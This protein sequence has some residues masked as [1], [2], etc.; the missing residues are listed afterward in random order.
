MV[1]VA[2]EVLYTELQQQLTLTDE[3]RE[4]L[5]VKRGFTDATID[6]LG[7]KSAIAS[8]GDIINSMTDKHGIKPMFECGLIEKNKA[9][10]WQFTQ[11][12]LI[13]IPYLYSDD[14]VYFY[15]SHK[16]AGLKDSG[17]MPYCNKITGSVDDDTIVL[18]ESEFKAAAM[19]QM[20][21]KAL[22]LGGV[23]SFSG[24]HLDSLAAVLRG[25]RRIVI[26]FDTEVQDDPSFS[27]FKDSYKKRY[28]QY[29]WSYI[30][31]K[32]LHNY[33]NDENYKC[34]VEIASLPEEWMIDGKADIDSCVAEGKGREDFELIV[35]DALSPEAYR[36]WIKVDHQHLPWV[37][38]RMQAAFKN[39]KVFEEGG[40][41][42]TYV[43]KG[44]NTYT[45]Q[46][47]N[48]R[49]GLI[50][51]TKYKGKI[52]RDVQLINE[53]GDRSKSFHLESG[54]F[55]SISTFKES[56]L[57]TGDFLWR[58]NE[59]D[60]NNV[61]QAMFLETEA[62]PIELVDY[63][64]RYEEGHA[65]MFSN[66]MIFDD[67]D[68]I[69]YNEDID[70]FAKD[71]KLYRVQWQSND[72]T[73]RVKL[74]E[75][76]VDVTDVIAK[77]KGAWGTSG[78]I[79]LGYAIAT[80]FANPYFE[81]YKCFPIGLF[82]GE[83]GSGKSTL[84]DI[85][86]LALGFPMN[87]PS[88]NISNTTQVAMARKLAFYSSMPVRFDE[89]RQG[90]KK[91]EAKYSIL[92]SFYNRQNSAKGTRYGQNQT[93]EVEVRGSCMII[94]EQKP[95]DFALL[96]RC[97]PVYLS[98]SDKTLATLRMV[99]DLL[100]Q[101]EKLSNISYGILKDYKK[102]V[103]KFMKNCEDTRLGLAAMNKLHDVNFRAMQHFAAVLA[104]LSIIMTEEE[105]LEC[106][107]DIIN[108]YF[109]Y[110]EQQSTETVLLSFLEDLMVMKIDGEKTENYAWYDINSSN[111]V[112]YMPGLYQMWSKWKRSRSGVQT[113]VPQTTINQYLQS[114][115]C[116]YKKVKRVL[117][118]VRNTQ[119]LIT[120]EFKITPQLPE[121]LR[122]LFGSPE[123]SNEII[124]G[125]NG[126][127]NS[128]NKREDGSRE[129][130][131]DFH[132]IDGAS[133]NISV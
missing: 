10:S 31:A 77:I 85:L 107:D 80:I 63:A 125:N 95:D 129:E 99:N 60:F 55:S 64:G 61:V 75:E 124:G 108:T 53:F 9:P 78:V 19:Y 62:N 23:A 65:W 45:K 36:D 67:G 116:F 26:L 15:K 46:I 112:I 110:I 38:R 12:G 29:V 119:R 8:N 101:G 92:R 11:S 113:P 51:T 6:S 33:L 47:S 21:F 43:I 69:K 117:P 35:R 72:P 20:G 121:A 24:K 81:K 104:G 16:R 127:D 88:L 41:L 4:S 34:I 3:D 133:E 54:I 13:I 30:M 17:V 18:C 102:N 120:M 96:T 5:K 44:K 66:M 71:D 98:K 89:H 91:I 68:I 83:A 74:S 76:E 37:R 118:N 131:F 57:G 87:N 100:S 14:R 84:S 114:Q 111:G 73:S 103:T 48:F 25:T 123:M 79:A 40:C 39:N 22:G 90:D 52:F 126:E 94:G 2:N 56:C 58:G 7:F 59:Q 128:S 1:W 106:K 49:I 70:A 50:A 130:S 28:A 97:V 109:C 132:A 42:Y 105:L 86:A 122:I 82:H 115:T 32:K 27:N 93:F